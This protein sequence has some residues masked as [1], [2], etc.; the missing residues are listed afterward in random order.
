MSNL[1]GLILVPDGT[2]AFSANEN[3]AFDE[4]CLRFSH[5][6]AIANSHCIDAMARVA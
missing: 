2:L 3:P 6:F 5:L 4:I 1:I